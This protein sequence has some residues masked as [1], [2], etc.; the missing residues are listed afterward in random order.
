M[1]AS[2]IEASADRLRDARRPEGLEPPKFDALKGGPDE[3][4]ER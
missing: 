3:R 1:H 4:G 2:L